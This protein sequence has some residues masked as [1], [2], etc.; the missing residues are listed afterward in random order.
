[1]TG[2]FLCFRGTKVLKPNL[3]T[4][5]SLWVCFVLIGS[6][7]RDINLAYK[8]NENVLKNNHMLY[9]SSVLTVHLEPW[10]KRPFK[11]GMMWAL[12]SDY[13]MRILRKKQHINQAAALP[14][15]P[16][17]VAPLAFIYI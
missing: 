10:K 12:R 15:P 16:S 14:P 8:L 2:F 1:M 5:L 11:L 4:F 17:N 13:S 7:T 9:A 3:A 6:A